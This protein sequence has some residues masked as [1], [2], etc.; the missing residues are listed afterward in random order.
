MTKAPKAKNEQYSDEE[1]TRRATAALRRALSTPYK[2]Q[3][4]MIGKVGRNAKPKPRRAKES[5]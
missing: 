5:R 3:N 4:K 1:A 2:P